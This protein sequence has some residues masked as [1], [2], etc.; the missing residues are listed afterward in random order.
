MMWVARA[1]ESGTRNLQVS[2]VKDLV[3]IRAN[4]IDKFV[5]IP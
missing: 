1:K 4:T 5:Q 3:Q 2:F